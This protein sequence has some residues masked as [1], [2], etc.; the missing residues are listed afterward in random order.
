MQYLNDFNLLLRNK[1]NHGIC[2]KSRQQRQLSNCHPKLYS[3]IEDNDVNYYNEE[4]EISYYNYDKSYT[5]TLKA[6][7]AS[8]ILHDNN[9]ERNAIEESIYSACQ[10]LT[11]QGILTTSSVDG[12]D[13]ITADT[14]TYI[15]PVASKSVPGC[16]G[17]VLLLQATIITS[18][19]NNDTVA[20]SEE[21]FITNELKI[22]IAQELDDMLFQ[23]QRIIQPILVSITTDT[24]IPIT[25]HDVTSTIKLEDANEVMLESYLEFIV[26][27]EVEQYD[28]VVPILTDDDEHVYQEEQEEEKICIPSLQVE[29]DG[30]TIVMT[31]TTTATAIEQHQNEQEGVWDT[32][33]VLV[34][35]DLVSDDLRQ[36]LL[37][38]V[39]G[40][41]DD[42]N[43]DN[44]WDDIQNGPDPTRWQ[45]GGLMDLPTL[46]HLEEEE[47][48]EAPGNSGG[49]VGLSDEAIHDLCFQHHDAIQEFETQILSNIFPSNDNN[50]NYKICRLPPNVVLGETVSPL[51]ANAPIAGDVYSYHIDADPNMTPPSPWTDIYGRYMN[52]SRGKPRFM[53]CL[54]YLNDEW[55]YDEW[56]GPTRFLDVATDTYY[57]VE[58]KP[59]RVVIMD[60]DI[61]HS[62]VAPKEEGSVGKRPRY[63]LVWKLILHPVREGQDMT[64]R[65]FHEMN[66]WP[67]PILWGSAQR[68]NED[69]HESQT[70]L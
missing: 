5:V 47:D 60:Q 8:G 35:D 10:K 50:P 14:V 22:A 37:N 49:G 70:D 61:T 65:R 17:R 7:A 25:K 44:D 27:H 64:F 11:E 56:G 18:Q 33:S 21:E 9:D 41:D 31:T 63:S 51:T 23:Q 53:S 2:F 12:M 46:E 16:T 68:G 6:I 52:R 36:R 30:A 59:G 45:K 66:I 4:E 38:V 32:S 42:N 39:L 15:P 1:Q 20:I 19:N 55:K 69:E 58:P 40:K 29:V 13:H 57:D 24:T 43:N 3:I 54:V 67:K 48:V 28:M 34:F 26:T 62:V